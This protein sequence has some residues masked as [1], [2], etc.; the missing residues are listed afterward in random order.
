MG[1]SNRILKFGFRWDIDRDTKRKRDI[2]IHEIECLSNHKRNTKVL[3][4]MG[5]RQRSR[6]KRDRGRMKGNTTRKLGVFGFKQS[7]FT[8]Y[9]L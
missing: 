2:G 5:Y 9:I 1:T 7:T 6:I 8:H 3:V 4:K